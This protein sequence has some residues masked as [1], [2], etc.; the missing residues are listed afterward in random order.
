MTKRIFS[1][2]LILALT[3][4]VTVGAVA[5]PA[6]E[7]VIG[8]SQPLT[9]TNAQVGA[10]TMQTLD[11]FIKRINEQGG[12]NGQQLRLVSYDDQGSPEEAV[13]IATKLI[14]VDKVDWVFA[15]LVSSCALATGQFFNEAK[16]PTI[17]TGI[18]PTWMEKDWEYV[19]RA[20]ANRSEERRVG[21]ECR[22]RW[23]PYH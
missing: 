21:K 11:L 10:V 13:K 3:L 7:L 9:G 23:S 1:I 15:S 2:L 8:T 6:K 4:S 5:E 12:L 19:F 18:S 14:E 16:L 22:S 17:G 20:T